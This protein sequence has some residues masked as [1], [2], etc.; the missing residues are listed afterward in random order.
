LER[1]SVHSFLPLTMANG[2]GARCCLW[3]QGCTLGCPSCF[4]PDTHKIK[5]DSSFGVDEVFS[6]INNADPIEGITVSGG[7]P[8]QQASGLMDLLFKIKR[9]TNLTIIVFSGFGLEEIQNMPCFKTLEKTVDVLIAGRFVEGMRRQSGFTGSS[10]KTIHFFSD[11]YCL[12]DLEMV[13][14]SEVII[15]RTG[16]LS[17]T[18]VEPPNLRAE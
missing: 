7:E 16:E 11:R 6:W 12:D 13:P 9:E 8:L 10:N 1:L 14:V 17:V 4:N 3:L 2:P 18:G 5:G 15:S